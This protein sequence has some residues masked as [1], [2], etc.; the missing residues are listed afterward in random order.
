MLLSHAKQTKSRSRCVDSTT[1]EIQTSCCGR[2][3]RRISKPRDSRKERERE[4][5]E[6]GREEEEERNRVRQRTNGRKFEPIPA[7]LPSQHQ[8]NRQLVH[9]P[10]PTG[11]LC[12]SCRIAIIIN[13]G[14]CAKQ[15]RYRGGEKREGIHHLLDSCCIVPKST[16][17]PRF[18]HNSSR[19]PLPYLFPHPPNSSQRTCQTI[20][21][22][23]YTENT[24]ISCSLYIELF[25]AF[26][27][28]IISD[29]LFD[30]FWRVTRQYYI[31]S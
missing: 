23:S 20:L 9:C 24:L 6:K 21:L 10:V 22:R 12:C 18:S 14:C 19:D 1:K 17:S 31:F 25:L 4:E 26:V 8:P 27:Y 7:G 30:A 29:I 15:R 3:R 2:K 11:V 28:L 16:R 13:E 5:E